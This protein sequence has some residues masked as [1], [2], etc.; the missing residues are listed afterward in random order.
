MPIRKKNTLRDTLEDTLGELASHTED[1]RQQVVERAPGVRDQ[2]IAAMPDKEQLLDLRDDLFEKLPDGV[3][4]KLPERVKPRRRR[5]RKVAVVGILTGAGAAAFAIVKRRGET[6][7][8]YT[9][10]PAPR[11]PA[12]AAPK[13]PTPPAPPVAKPAPDAKA[14]KDDPT[15]GDPFT[16]EPRIN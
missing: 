11:P 10:P 4:E 2:V 13:P 16:A 3:Q 15:D 1:L 8:T 7:P 6:P 12:A 14:T 5:L 9:P